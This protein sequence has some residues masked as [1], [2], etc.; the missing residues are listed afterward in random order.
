MMSTF[1]K[2]ECMCVGVWVREGM[3]GIS[4]LFKRK[5]LVSVSLTVMTRKP[6][7]MA[8]FNSYNILCIIMSINRNWELG[9]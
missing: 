1:E 5:S 7:L 4:P 3:V 2:G 9:N 8:L 6:K